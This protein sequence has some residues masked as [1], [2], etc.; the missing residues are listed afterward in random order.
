L[1]PKKRR[2]SSKPRLKLKRSLLKAKCLKRRRSLLP[3]P[4]LLLMPQLKLTRD[5]LQNLPQLLPKE[6]PTHGTSE[7]EMDLSC[8][9]QSSVISFQTE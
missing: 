2:L 6:E 9:I 1:P 3:P 7:S 4:R 8:K 5:F